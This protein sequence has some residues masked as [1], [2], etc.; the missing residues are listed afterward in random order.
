VIIPIPFLLQPLA[1]SLPA[2]VT[3]LTNTP[4]FQV[5][6]D[7]ILSI[8]Q[9]VETILLASPTTVLLNTTTIH[10]RQVTLA[11]THMDL[12]SSTSGTLSQ[13][14][15]ANHAM[16]ISPRPQ[17]TVAASLAMAA[18]PV[19]VQRTLAKVITLLA[20]AVTTLVPAMMP[21]AVAAMILSL[22]ELPL[23]L[24]QDLQTR[25][26]MFSTLCTVKLLPT[27]ATLSHKCKVPRS[28]LAHLRMALAGTA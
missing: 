7:T 23:P 2:E 5:G 10:H 16:T 26:P 20:L 11:L 17:V 9:A 12:P 28:L 4:L 6:V 24:V 27:C 13:P 25:V 15:R 18:P 14:A 1:L 19:M 21:Q 22:L 8:S 3:T